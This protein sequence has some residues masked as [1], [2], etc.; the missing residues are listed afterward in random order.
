MIDFADDLQGYLQDFGRAVTAKARTGLGVI[1]HQSEIVVKGEIVY[2]GNSILT[3]QDIASDLTHGDLI[4]YHGVT[5]EVLHDPFASADG[6][7]FRVPVR[8]LDPTE[9][10]P[11]IIWGGGAVPSAGVIYSGGGA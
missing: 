7:F 9:V 3:S 5:Y 8:R 11:V 6:F 2:T 4:T 10:P 1:S